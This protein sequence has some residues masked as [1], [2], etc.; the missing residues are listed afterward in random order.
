M[1]GRLVAFAVVALLVIAAPTRARAWYFPE[2]VVLTGDGHGELP[3]EIRAVISAAVAA[4]RTEGLSLCERT[5]LRLED[6]LLEAPLQTAMLRT[7]KSVA[8][9]PYAALSGLAGDH[10]SDVAELRT[11]L[12]TRK[13]IEL[14]STVAYE[15]LR[16]RE[17]AQRGQTSLD[18]MS[19]VHELDVALYFLDPGYVTRARATRVHFRD[20]GRPFDATLRDLATDGRIDEVIARFIF[21]H[22]RSL[23]LARQSKRADA[24]LDHAFAVHFLQDAFASGHLVMSNDSWSQ[25]RDAVRWRHDAF[26]ADGLPVTRVMG[27]EPCSTLAT[28]TLEVA[29]L[30]PCWTTSGDGYLSI[31]ADASDRLHAAAA[32]SRAEIAFAMALDPDRVLAYASGLGDLEVVAFATKLDPIPWWTVEASLRRKLPAGP[33]HAMRIIRSAAA[34]ATKLGELALPAAAGVDTAR[35]SGAV[36][37]AVIA[38]VLDSP[39]IFS[40]ADEEAHD[41][42]TGTLPERPESAGHAAGLSLLRPTLAQLPTAQADT[43][44]M[45]PEGHL[46]HGWAIQIFAG[47]SAMVL[48]PPRSPV[49]F[50]GPGVGVAA[51]FSYRWG[52]LLPGRRARAIAELNVGVSQTL[53]VDSGGNTGGSAALTLLDQELRWPVIWEALTQYNLPLD[54]ASMHNAGRVLFFNG[55]RSHEVLRSG[56]MSFLGVEVEAVAIALSNGHGSHPL[57]ALSPE[58]RFYVGLANPSATQPSF[59]AALGPTFGITLSGGYASQLW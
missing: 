59:P 45:R 25:G 27:R 2:H 30:T 34:A 20:V 7:P 56:S 48:V 12:T 37:P 47:T 24:L 26:N 10:S 22:M 55:A 46:D 23:I 44:T 9:V 11:V 28:G 1:R 3:P 38:G 40:D 33:K 8:C 17:S 18:R 16:F 32:L 39:H 4:A 57:Y 43:T 15:W 50:V 41:A 29:G 51:G 36:D 54:L 42:T 13:G 21:H 6:A 52:T 19:F 49:D 35:E 5:D 14:V 58:L 53:H 31:N